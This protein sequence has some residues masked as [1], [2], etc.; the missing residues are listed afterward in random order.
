MKITAAVV[1]SGFSN[2]EDNVLFCRPED[3]QSLSRF[4]GDCP[5]EWVDIELP[6][7]VAI[8]GPDYGRLENFTDAKVPGSSLFAWASRKYDPKKEDWVR[9]IHITCDCGHETVWTR[10]IEY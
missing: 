10:T 5:S 9:K 4:I 7:N 8:D 6:D 2:V 3:W 1:S